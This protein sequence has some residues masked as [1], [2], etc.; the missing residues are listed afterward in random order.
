MDIAMG[1]TRAKKLNIL[2]L[3]KGLGSVLAEACS[4]C[5]DSQGHKSPVRLKVEGYAEQEYEIRFL[6][7]TDQML[8]TYHDGEEATEH[9]AVCLAL[10]VVLENTKYTVVERSM[11]KTG[12]DYW[13]GSKTEI[14][15]LPFEK[16]ARLEVSGIRKGNRNAVMGRVSQKQNQTKRSESTRLPAFVVVS[17]FGE[18]Y[19]YVGRVSI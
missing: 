6:K 11:K 3:K 7:V 9:G 15:L 14:D 13:L 17:E 18:P 4:V 8:R 12:I 10:L 19:A 1:A 16:K 2:K 5:L